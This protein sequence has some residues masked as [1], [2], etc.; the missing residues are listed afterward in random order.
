[1]TPESEIKKKIKD[2]IESRGGFW[3]AVKGGAHSKTGD[4]DLIVCYKGRFVG[5]E[6]KTCTGKVSDW[7]M[8]RKGQIESAGGI[9]CIARCVEDVKGALDDIDRWVDDD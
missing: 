1:M 6:V 5:V 2:Y 9:F 3:T 7:Q 8:L 4:P